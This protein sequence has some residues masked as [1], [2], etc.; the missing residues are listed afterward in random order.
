LKRFNADQLKLVLLV[1]A[2]IL[3]GVVL[4]YLF[5]TP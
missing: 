4:R 3:A 2:V 5:T 1:G